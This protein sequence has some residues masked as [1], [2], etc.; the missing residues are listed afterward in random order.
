M[1]LLE[2]CFPEG[3]GCLWYHHKAKALCYEQD[4][5]LIQDIYLSASRTKSILISAD[6]MPTESTDLVATGARKEVDV[7]NLQRLHAKGAFHRVFLSIRAARHLC[8]RRAAKV[9]NNLIDKEGQHLRGC[10]KKK[11]QKKVIGTCRNLSIVSFYILLL[12]H[13]PSPHANYLQTH[14]LLVNNQ[15]LSL[16]SYLWVMQVM[17][18]MLLMM[19]LPTWICKH[20]FGNLLAYLDFKLYSCKEML[21]MYDVHYCQVLPAPFTECLLEI[22]Y[23]FYSGLHVQDQFI[24]FPRDLELHLGHPFKLFSR[25]TELLNRNNEKLLTQSDSFLCPPPFYFFVQRPTKPQDYF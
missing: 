3:K 4:K 25:V 13:F 2:E 19:F 6:T 15:S 1:P 10:K 16:S 7:I 5:L 14:K 9:Y 23:K 24:P 18:K 21:R 11:Q 22:F 20:F 12:H 17:W 8:V